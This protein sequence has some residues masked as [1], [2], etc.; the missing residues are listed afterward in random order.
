MHIYLYIYIYICKIWKRKKKLIYIRHLRIF[1]KH[2]VTSS[3]SRVVLT[4]I[5]LSCK[6]SSWVDP[7][8][9]FEENLHLKYLTGF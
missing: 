4:F 5:E 6:N 8:V 1:R 3:F 2:P 7:L 9:I